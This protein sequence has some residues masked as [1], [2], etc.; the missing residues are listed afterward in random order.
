VDLGKIFLAED[1]DGDGVFEDERVRVVKLV[2]GA[3]HGYT[4][5]GSRWCGVLHL[6]LR[7]ADYISSTSQSYTSI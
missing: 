5:G 4:E 6:Y 7:I 2:R 3:A 1:W